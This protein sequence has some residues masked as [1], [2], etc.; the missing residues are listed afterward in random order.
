LLLY[1][2]T[3]SWASYFHIGP[4]TYE[5]LLSSG[6]TTLLRDP[7]LRDALAEYYRGIDRWDVILDV[8]KARFSFQEAT[9]G[10]LNSDQLTAIETSDEADFEM[11]GV[12]PNEVLALAQEFAARDEAVRFLPRMLHYHVL[13]E[14]VIGRHEI[15]AKAMLDRLDAALASGR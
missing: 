1:L 6:R 8:K 11:P 10:L 3:S 2:E 13:A 9:A 15:S 12:D 4:R 5:E 14:K 7:E